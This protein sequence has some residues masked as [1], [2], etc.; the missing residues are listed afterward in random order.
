MAKKRGKK[1][2]LLKTV[3]I[4]VPEWLIPEN[5]EG[6]FPSKLNY[7]GMKCCLGFW[8]KQAYG[9]PYTQM[10]D[11]SVPSEL[12]V[13]T[14]AGLAC[15]AAACEEVASMFARYGSTFEDA[16]ATINDDTSLTFSQRKKKLTT[17]FKKVGVDL[18]FAGELRPT[19]KKRPAPRA[20]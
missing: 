2:P 4:N 3:T 12:F 14:K 20:Q 13:S 6:D 10:K 5:V 16:A 17:L 19:R 15:E 9:V 18:R 8:A 1:K 11:L 7:G